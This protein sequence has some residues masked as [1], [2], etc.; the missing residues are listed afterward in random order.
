[1]DRDGVINKNL[2]SNVTRWEEFE[3]EAQ[4]VAAIV[5]LAQ[6]D[7]ALVVITNQSGIGRGQMTTASVEAIHA[8]MRQEV[9]RAGGR[10]DRVY[11]CPHLPGD[12]C[13][14]RKPAPGL[15]LQACDELGLDLGR[16]YFIGDWVDDIRAAQNAQVTPILVL[17]GRGAEAL[18]TL[19]AN[20]LGLP[21]RFANL[22][23]AVS[24]ILKQEALVHS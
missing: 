19:R 6:T 24:W 9:S 1:L 23:E 15:I 22:S 2:P 10:I 20:S 12:G 14:C 3:F 8:R 11:F 21:E 13:A 7:F 16:S 4:S 17:T 5:R 18:D